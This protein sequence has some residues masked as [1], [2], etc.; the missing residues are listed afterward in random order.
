MKNTTLIF[1]L[2]GLGVGAGVIWYFFLREDQE[3]YTLTNGV[4]GTAEELIAKG[5]M[6]IQIGSEIQWVSK[7][8]YDKAQEEAN[9][10]DSLVVLILDT[11][12]ALLPV[13]SSVIRRL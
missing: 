4:R 7:T 10:D 1:I 2:I 5:Y 13:A 11:L 12:G 3:E 8:E 9:G 6:P